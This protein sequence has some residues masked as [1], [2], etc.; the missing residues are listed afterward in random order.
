M[1]KHSS[2]ATCSVEPLEA[3]RLLSAAVENG[4]L[5][6]VGTNAADSIVVSASAPYAVGFYVV[7]DPQR[8][9]RRLLKRSA[10]RRGRLV[11][12]VRA[13]A[14]DDTSAGRTRRVGP[15]RA[16]PLP[17]STSG[18]GNDIIVGTAAADSIKVRVRQRPDRR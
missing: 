8:E 5:V 16:R 10:S 18:P 9:G 6:I 14:G 4:S 12:H 3:R 11:R 2:Q 1:M 17:R 15:G 13:L 7:L